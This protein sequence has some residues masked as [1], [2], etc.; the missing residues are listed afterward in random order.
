MSRGTDD[1]PIPMAPKLASLSVSILWPIQISMAPRLNDVAKR[2]HVGGRGSRN[3]CTVCAGTD[4]WA[5][6]LLDDRIWR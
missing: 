6:E 1:Q 2:R 4:H 3:A 5:L